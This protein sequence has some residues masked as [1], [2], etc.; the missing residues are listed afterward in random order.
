MFA[1]EDILRRI[2]L[3][4]VWIFLTDQCNLNCDYCFFKYRTNKNYLSFQK[5]KNIFN[6]LPKNKYLNVVISGGEPCYQWDTVETIFKYIKDNF[7]IYNLMIE[8]N[9]LFLENKKIKFIRDYDIVVE[10]GIDGD[11]STTAKHRKGLSKQKF[12]ELLKKIKLILES[13][14]KVSPTMTVHPQEADKMFGNFLF[15]ISLGLYSID[16]HPA[17]FEEWTEKSSHL[18]IK[19]YK[20]IAEYERNEK[21]YLLN[22]S[23]SLPMNLSLDFV[24]L[25]TGEILPNWVYLCLRPSQRKKYFIGQLVDR[26]VVLFKDKFLFFL[27]QYKNFFSKK[28]SY[29][30][31]SNFNLALMNRDFQNTK[32][33]NTLKNYFK[34]W[35]TM[36]IVDFLNIKALKS[37]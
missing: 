1:L 30:E 11:Y 10:P 7:L 18:F 35:D 20:K 36:K 33:S 4:S 31:I 37:T 8:T 24:I 15:L 19:N 14:I 9:C 25:P 22:K 32:V 29:G 12:S 2:N 17:L 5:I 3:S 16:I 34:I 28:R 26:G 6:I 27:K 21:K 13:G 23:Y